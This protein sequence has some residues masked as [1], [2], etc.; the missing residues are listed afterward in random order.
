MSIIGQSLYAKKVEVEDY[1]VLCIAKVE[2][3]DQKYTLIG[4]LG[5]WWVFELTSLRRALSAFKSRTLE[6]LETAVSS[7]V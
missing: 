7:D 1:K 3:G 6:I 2:I 5:G 4:L